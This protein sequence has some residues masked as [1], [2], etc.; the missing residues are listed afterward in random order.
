VAG[1]NKSRKEKLAPLPKTKTGI[2]GFDEITFGGLPRG[3]PVLVCGSAGSGKTLFAME[4]LVRGAEWFGEPGVFM[5]FEETDAELTQNVSSLGFDLQALVAG[6]KLIL[7]HVRIERSEIEETGEYDLEALFVRLGYA[8]DM[9]GAKRVV[10]DTLEALFGA[11]PNQL[12]LRAEL[13]RLFRW[14]KARGVTAIIT[15][16]RGEGSL[17]RHGLEEY[18]SDCVILLDHRVSEENAIRRLRVVKY[19]GSP[20][21]TNEYPFIIDE[22]GF[23]VLPISSLTLDYP[24]GAGRIPSGIPAVDDMLEGKGYHRGSTVL[25]SGTAGTGKT[26]MAAHF[27][28]AACERGERCLL[29]AHEE[30]PSQIIRNMRSIGITLQRWVVKGL[31]RIDG[32]RPT[33]YSLETHL[34]QAQK[35]IDEFKPDL[36]VVDPI[37]NLLMMGTKREVT[38]L[39]MRL[40]DLIKMRGITALFT[41]VMGVTDATEMSRLELSSLM[42]TW[43]ILRMVERNGEQISLLTILKA[44]GIARSNQIR[45][46]IITRR[47]IELIPAHS[48]N[49]LP[50]R[51]ALRIREAENQQTPGGRGNGRR[52]L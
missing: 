29:I 51:S 7:D 24:V 11:F 22:T 50:A 36:V 49:G 20:H 2:A 52:K 21:G 38:A 5:A 18:I 13:R 3:R 1:H 40:V 14:L 35:D 44:R 32:V 8:I 6:N 4:F 46:F 43:M 10:L 47:G 28:E 41:S 39:L 23:S 45:E 9:V 27:L 48:D 42:D 12:I 37:D 26:S 16:E 25:V 33:Q 34:A 17:T 30:S 15:A 31:L 19:R